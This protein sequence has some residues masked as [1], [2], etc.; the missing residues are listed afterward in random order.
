MISLQRLEGFYW[1]ART[2]GYARAARSFPYPITQPGVHQQ[3]RRLEEELGTKLFERT[4]KDRVRLT[5]AGRALYAFVTPFLEGLT[6]LEQSLRANSFGGTLRVHAASL[7]L[8]HL[9]PPWLRKLQT[10]RPDIDVV[11]TEMR[12]TELAA[13]RSGEADL[14]VDYLPEIPADVEAQVVAKT[15]TFLALPSTHRLAGR[16]SVRLSDLGSDTFVAYNAD[17]GGRELQ[18]RALHLAGVRPARIYA[19]DSAE[20][21]LGF[22]AAGIGVSL[23]PSLSPHGP[24]VAGVVAHRMT[25]PGSVFPVHAARRKGGAP[26]PLVDA[27]L[28]LAPRP[29]A[30]D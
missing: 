3:V 10:K 4:G 19:A 29:D 9:L 23:V 12:R 6:G 21:I 2:E 27:A 24:K 11:L 22:V 7:H 5:A 18:L 25:L 14:L 17:I 15:F 26:N 20:T 30:Q 8:R 1:V 28:A 16:K 13:L